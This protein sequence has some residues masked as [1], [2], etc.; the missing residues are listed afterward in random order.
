MKKNPFFSGQ[1]III[2]LI[3]QKIIEPQ[4]LLTKTNDIIS[5]FFFYEKVV[6]V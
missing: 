5:C 4:N 3:A 1:R 2:S 6:W